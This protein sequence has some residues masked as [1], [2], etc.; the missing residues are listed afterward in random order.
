MEKGFEKVTRFEVIDETGRVLVL[1]N[2]TIQVALQDD[3][4]TCKVF[5]KNDDNILELP[6][7]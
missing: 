7:A 3:A 6:E 5:V 4:R 1:Y 2:V